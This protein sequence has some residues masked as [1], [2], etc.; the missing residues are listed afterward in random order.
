MDI[1][2]M[3]MDLMNRATAVYAEINALIRE[4][5]KK[6]PDKRELVF[7]ICDKNEINGKA[8]CEGIEDHII[9]NKGVISRFL[10]YFNMVNQY[11]VKR[12]LGKIMPEK[13]ESEFDDM[14]I[15]GIIPTVGRTMTFDSKDI[16]RE[17][18]ALLEIFVARFVLLHE[19]G[20]LFNGHCEYLSKKEE[21]F[22]YMPMYSENI[23]KDCALNR[24]TMEM[25]ADAFAVTRSFFH[26]IY[27]YQNFE[28]KVYC[29]FLEPMELFYLWSFAIRSHFLVCEDTFMDTN[30][31]STKMCHL[32]SSARWIMIAN[33]FIDIAKSLNP[34]EL[35]V[36][37]VQE[38]FMKGAIDAEKVFNT[39]K[40]TKYSF[41]EQLNDNEEFRYY[42]EEVNRNWENIVD[43]VEQ[44]SRVTLFRKDID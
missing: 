34:N 5:E 38:E 42:S 6:E 26:L 11:Y 41:I 1:D 14:S 37:R 21:G 22:K 39:I 27:L 3:C 44:F 31:F 17:R 32:P 24:R 19:M 28:E 10:T 36:E 16:V 25:D 29:T 18:T 40:Y 8:W 35:N 12:L 15:E 20:H 33:T 4:F 30:K 2:F 43:E 13:E 7:E 9:I 23:K